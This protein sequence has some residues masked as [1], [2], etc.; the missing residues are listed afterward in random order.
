MKK[1]ILL[2]MISMFF[3]L[4][5]TIFA[6]DK[7]QTKKV[8]ENSSGIIKLEE[9][10]ITL[11]DENGKVIEKKRVGKK[12]YEKKILIERVQKKVFKSL[13]VNSEEEYVSKKMVAAYDAAYKKY[14]KIKPIKNPI[15]K[16][17]DK[18]GDILKKIYL[19]PK[20]KFDIEYAKEK[21]KISEKIIRLA[22]NKSAA[23]SK[24]KKYVL[25]KFNQYQVGKEGGGRGKLQYLDSRG[26]ILWTIK[27]PKNMG[28]SNFKIADNGEIVAYIQSYEIGGIDINEPY[29]KLI[30][31]DREGK[32]KIIF[33][34]KRGN[35]RLMGDLIISPNGHYLYVRG[36]IEYKNEVSLFFDLTKGTFWQ[37]D[38]KYNPYKIEDN[39]VA[40]TS[41]YDKQTKGISN[42]TIDLKKFIG[43]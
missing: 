38:S 26:S 34:K 15:L 18:N 7:N 24:N 11:F 8:S 19:N 4:G 6:K 33:P 27:T 16:F 10:E 43:E 29:E 40:Y 39:G 2:T 31:V 1:I 42:E 12:S 32:L 23:V 25:L 14:I 41:Y 28:I 3:L 9:E 21:D 13:G 35:Y 36:R 17:L 37:A 5:G 30:V 22:V 20:T